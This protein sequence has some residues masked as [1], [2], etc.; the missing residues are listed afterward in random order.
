[1][2]MTMISAARMANGRAS[3]GIETHEA[4]TGV[5][6]SE[7]PVTLI[8]RIHPSTM[9][10]VPASMV[11]HHGH[12]LPMMSTD[13]ASRNKANTEAATM[14]NPS[15]MRSGLPG[16]NPPMSAARN[17]AIIGNRTRPNTALGTRVPHNGI[18]FDHALDDTA[19]QDTRELMSHPRVTARGADLMI[20]ASTTRANAAME[21][22]AAPTAATVALYPGLVLNLMESPEDDG[23]AQTVQGIHDDI[24]DSGPGPVCGEQV[25]NLDK[26]HKHQEDDHRHP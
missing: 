24:D 20:S 14:P 22:T 13:T 5:C 26:R 7:G 23:I 18:R 6:P 17:P 10:M 25:E 19:V 9:S 8:H 12:S 4:M 2:A 16:L 21:A 15:R 3:M 11:R 1:M